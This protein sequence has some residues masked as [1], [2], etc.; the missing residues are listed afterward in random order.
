VTPIHIV[1]LAIVQGVAEF[2]PISS[3]GHLV[4]ANA[5]LQAMGYEPPPELI[6]ISIVLHLGTLASILLYYW[7]R[8]WRLLGSDRRV[9]SL[10]IVGTLPA[11]VVG[12]VCSRNLRNHCSFM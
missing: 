5:L 8:V 12:L 4:V 2:L 7:H 3:S 11:V 9:I 6:E 1:I 10:M